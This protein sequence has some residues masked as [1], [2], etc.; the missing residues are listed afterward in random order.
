M[1][2]EVE[3]LVGKL[4]GEPCTQKEVGRFKSLSLGFGADSEDHRP[5]VRRTYKAWELGTYNCEWRFIRNSV[6]LCG[7]RD[8]SDL[9]ELNAAIDDIQL[10]RLISLRQLTEF[11]I[12]LEFANGI[13]VD[14]LAATSV[15]D[16]SFHVFCPGS[17]SIVFSA[18]DGWRTGPSNEPWPA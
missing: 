17:L 8:S 14:F 9:T 12:R 3:L 11:D 15:E 16:E 18:R 2:G 6:V 1:N 5:H 10:G 4:I 7:S 13:M